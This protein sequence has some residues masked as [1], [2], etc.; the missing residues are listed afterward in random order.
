MRILLS[1]LLILILASP[2]QAKTIET[3][4]AII[5]SPRSGDALQGHVNISGSISMTGF[6]YADASF[7]YA[8]DTTETWFLISMISQPVIND[9]LTTWDTTVISD[10]NY[11]LRMR[12]YL[13]DGSFSESYVQ[14]LRLRNYMPLETPTPMALIPEATPFPIIAF[15]ST[16][17]ATPTILP[18]NQ[19]VLA[20]RDV[21]TS[22]LFGG[23]V[24]CLIFVIFLIYLW[25][26]RKF[27]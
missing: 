14:G 3:G 20:P 13:I 15:T 9:V 25:V 27:L 19:A 5:V 26:R 22:F 2:A 11:V 8:N 6:V 24:S 7:T 10:G 18:H 4:E 17:Y 23:M 1:L 12:V 16:T 21:S